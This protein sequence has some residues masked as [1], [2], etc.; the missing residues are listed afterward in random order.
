MNKWAR[1]SGHLEWINQPVTVGSFIHS[2]NNYH[3]PNHSLSANFREQN[4]NKCEQREQNECPSSRGIY[5]LIER[6]R[7]VKNSGIM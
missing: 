2:S 1:K 3:V 6:G 7:K 4:M 5:I